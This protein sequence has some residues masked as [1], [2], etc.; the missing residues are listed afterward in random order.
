[1]QNQLDQSQQF[2]CI[3]VKKPIVPDP[4][5]P[6]GQHMLHDQM[7]KVLAVEGPISCIAGLAFSI[8]KRD[9]AVLIG[10]DIFLADHAPV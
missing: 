5:E 10:N 6:F 7:Q 8:F 3:P 2:F 9:P 4:P 1:M